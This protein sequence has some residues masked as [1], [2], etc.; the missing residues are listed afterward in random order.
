MSVFNY[1]TTI[2]VIAK[3]NCVPCD[4]TFC[5]HVTAILCDVIGQCLAMCLSSVES[6]PTDDLCRESALMMKL[7]K[8]ITEL[9][10]TASNSRQLPQR[11]PSHSHLNC[12]FIQSL[13]TC[14]SHCQIVN[15]MIFTLCVFYFTALSFLWSVF[16]WWPV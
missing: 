8:F 5:G 2:R 9:L 3:C 12:P 10:T 4:W 14:H 6:R 1:D 11:V 7:M 16:Y 15:V 13:G